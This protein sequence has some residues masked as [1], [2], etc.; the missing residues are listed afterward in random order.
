LTGVNNA[1]P[2]N[3]RVQ[4]PLISLMTDIFQEK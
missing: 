3:T 2:V 4:V 1:C